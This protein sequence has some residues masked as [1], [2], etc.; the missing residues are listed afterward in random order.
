MTHDECETLLRT[1]LEFEPEDVRSGARLLGSIMIRRLKAKGGTFW[2]NGYFGR[3]GY[4]LKEHRMLERGEIPHGSF[5]AH[6]ETQA[7]ARLWAAARH[8][9]ELRDVCV[10][11]GTRKAD[12]PHYELR[13]RLFW[14]P[15]E[16]SLRPRKTP[17]GTL[18][19]L[20]TVMAHRDAIVGAA[21]RVGA[22]SVNV[23]GEITGPHRALSLFEEVSGYWGD[24][25]P[26]YLGFV[27]N[28]RGIDVNN[29]RTDEYA[30]EREIENLLETRVHV[31]VTAHRVPL[32]HAIP[33]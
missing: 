13:V 9:E 12:I 5:A 16:V 15:K 21:R 7:L 30:L 11:L 23:V 28:A 3:G 6:P 29:I 4:P 25:G 22:E 27:V 31:A 18:P 17:P 10:R 19:I 20:E 24:G 26:V 14:E 2:A 33:L 1:A 8:I 32:Y